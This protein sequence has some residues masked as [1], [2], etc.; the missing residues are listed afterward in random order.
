V[1]QVARAAERAGARLREGEAVRRLAREGERVTAVE[2]QAGRY[3]PG[4][5][6]LAAGAWSGGLARDL[7]L[8]LPTRPVKGQ[9]LLADCRAAPV[10]TPLFAGEALL[11]PRP[12][13]RLVVGVTVEEAG[14]DER[15]TLGGL[16]HIL[17][18]AC[19]LA[20]AVAGLPLARAW[21]GLRPGTPDGLPYL[22]P[23][24]TLRNLWASTG[25]FRKGVLLAPLCA[26]LLCGAILAGRAG[27]ELAP[28]APGRH[29]GG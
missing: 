20:P 21:A 1:R 12:E 7:G 16:R 22:G 10:S 19:A 28:F 5:V 29:L 2:T 24:P 8:E 13:G 17:Q 15:V 14:F 23:V 11:V 4:A 18:G 25:H 6:V 3:L 27:G 26:R 9:L